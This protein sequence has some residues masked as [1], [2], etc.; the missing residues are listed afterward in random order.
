MQFSPRPPGFRSFRDKRFVFVPFHGVRDECRE[1]RERVARLFLLRVRGRGLDRV[2]EERESKPQR[3]FTT[4]PSS[5]TTTVEI[6]KKETQIRV[7]KGLRGFHTDLE[8]GERG[9]ICRISPAAGEMTVNRLGTSGF[10]RGSRNNLD[11]LG[12]KPNPFPFLGKIYRIR[13]QLK[14]PARAIC[15][16][17]A[18]SGKTFPRLRLKI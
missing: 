8:R 7:A 2:E 9:C 11:L 15:S 18:R 16:L 4:R 13:E 14:R 12:T 3:N 6:F 5:R 17:R 10:E 1:A